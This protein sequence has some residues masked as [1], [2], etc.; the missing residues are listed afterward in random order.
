M[1][2]KNA[3]DNQQDNWKMKMGK[4]FAAPRSTYDLKNSMIVSVSFAS[5]K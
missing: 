2:T 5:K 1:T 3:N 4:S